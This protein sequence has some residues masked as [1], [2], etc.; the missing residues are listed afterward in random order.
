MIQKGGVVSN[1]GCAENRNERGPESMHWA[2]GKPNRVGWNGF[3]SRA[4]IK[5]CEGE[6]PHFSLVFL[7]LLF[8]N[9]NALF[10]L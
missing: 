9:E 3:G 4:T 5:G 8:L 10:S 1:Q 2:W 6:I 7:S